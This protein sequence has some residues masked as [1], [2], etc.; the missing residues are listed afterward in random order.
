MN[1]LAMRT[2]D[3]A[4]VN[5]EKIAGLFPHCVTEAHGADGELQRK[6]D[7]DLLRQELSS[8]LI[9]GAEERYRL[10]WPGKRQALYTGNMPINKTLRPCRSDSVDFDRSENLFIEGDNLD[11]LKLLQHTYMGKVKMI[12]IDPP[13]NTGKDF[14]YRDNYATSRAEYL[15]RSSQVD[16]AGNRLVANNESN[17]RFHSDWLSMMYPRLRLAQKL[18]RDDG[19]IFISIDDNEQASLKRLCDEVFG[20]ANFRNAILVKRGAKSVQAQFDTWDKLGQGSEYILFY[21]KNSTY[22][23]PKIE[24]ELENYKPGYWNNHW[25]GTD[26]PTMR[27]ELLGIMPKHGQWRWSKQ[28]SL[29]AIKNYQLMLSETQNTEES[30]KEED[31]DRWYHSKGERIDLLRLSSNNKP[32]HFIPPTDSQLLTNVWFDLTSGGSFDIKNLMPTKLF[33]N[34]KSVNLLKR[35][36]S[37]TSSSDIV[38]DFFSG[39]ATTAH[40]V[41]QLNA[42]DGG[43]RKFIMV[44]LP[45]ACDPKSEA[46]KAGY[47]T[48]A[49]IGRERIRRAGAKILAGEC[50]E[51]WNKDVGFRSLLVDSSNMNNTYYSPAETQQGQLDLWARE[52]IKLERS[53]EDLLF[54]VLLDWGLGLT[55]PI[56]RQQICGLEVFIVDDEQLVA[57]FAQAG[58]IDDELFYQLAKRRPR[59]ALFRSS[60]LTVDSTQT[61]AEQIFGL[62]S[63]ST[64]IKIL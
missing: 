45:E 49:D 57:C 25:R 54:Q 20:E 48:I 31:I 29:S 24:K 59:R 4:S 15:R 11:V 61:N 22:R 37:F 50:H 40:A 6:I 1:K 43:N 44:Q 47:K 55:L 52:Y 13:Y 36:F 7:W 58:E 39:S 51:S 34:P 23:F 9:Q 12:Y 33:N 38:L 14:I 42:E 63:P 46:Y 21:S 35:I 16:D 26:R 64:E 28:R 53:G 17:G 5:V 41:M 27:Y 56:E 32:E 62:I 18:L 8:D 10:D 19:V 2:P 30:I 3:L 60:G